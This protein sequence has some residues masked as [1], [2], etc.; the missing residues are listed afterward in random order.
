MV[1]Y[2]LLALSFA[3]WTASIPQWFILVMFFGLGMVAAPGQ[4]LYPHLKE[5]VS[6]AM[7]SQ[8]MT[9]LNFF[10]VLGAGLM[11]HLIGVLMGGE[12]SLLAGPAEFRGIWY[13]GAISL[14]VVCLLYLPVPDSQA[15]RPKKPA[16]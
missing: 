15:L 10:T 8:A 12:P 14:A 4:I 13:A 11:T 5:L 6:P 7:I 9:A 16:K 3:W 1:V 2:G